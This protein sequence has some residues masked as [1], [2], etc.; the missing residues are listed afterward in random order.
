MGGRKRQLCRDNEN[1]SDHPFFIRYPEKSPQ[2]QVKKSRNDTDQPKDIINKQ[3]AFQKLSFTDFNTIDLDLLYLVEPS[4][5]WQGMSRYKSFIL[6][7][8][9]YERNDFIFV[10]NEQS[11]KRQAL[12]DGTKHS[13]VRED[14]E[15]T[16]WVAR[17]LEIR[18]SDQNHVY[19]CIHWLYRPCD[20]PNGTLEGKKKIHGRQPYHATKEL[21]FSNHLDVIDVLS[22]MGPADVGQWNGSLNEEIKHTLFWRQTYDWRRSRISSTHRI[23]TCQTPAN[24]DKEHLKCTSSTCGKWMHYECLT[25]EILVKT[26]A[27]LATNDPEQVRGPFSDVPKDTATS[28]SQPTRGIS[29]Q[30][31]HPQ[32]HG[33]NSPGREAIRSPNFTLRTAVSTHGQTSLNLNRP[34]AKSLGQRKDEELVSGHVPYL[35]L[36]EA[37][38]KTD[39]GSVRWEIHDRRPNA[40]E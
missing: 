7:G 2:A 30:K 15:D 37:E 9:K 35:E 23:C 8:H 17:V 6:G 40:V 31:A 19:A 36:L 1:P 25:H 22:V 10:A 32:T 12:M 33:L 3:T 21:I 24:P 38:L 11:V 5:T 39:E 13:G 27:R 18:A 4:K 29:V 16:N 34:W 26:L 20:L 28:S 14:E